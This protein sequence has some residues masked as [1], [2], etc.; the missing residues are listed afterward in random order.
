MNKILIVLYLFIS[1]TNCASSSDKRESRK[2]RL[3]KLE[4]ESKETTEAL[5][6]ELKRKNLNTEAEDAFKAGKI[7]QAIKLIKKSLKL[8]PDNNAT[9][10]VIAS[11]IFVEQRIDFLEKAIKSKQ[12][13][14]DSEGKAQA[15]KDLKNT[16][17]K[18]HIESIIKKYSDYIE[19]RE[20]LYKEYKELKNKNQESDIEAILDYKKQIKTMDSDFDITLL[21]EKTRAANPHLFDLLMSDLISG[22]LNPDFNT[23]LF[24]E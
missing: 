2:A 11:K 8:S 7:A 10:N 13:V 15:L 17:S 4:S 5:K 1:A 16:N 20:K 6:Q 3:A 14:M 24:E 23:Y 21:N 19:N 9:G 22:N 18:A 12:S